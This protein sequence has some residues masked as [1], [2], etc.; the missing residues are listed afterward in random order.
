[1]P[2]G[3]FRSAASDADAAARIDVQETI[4]DLDIGV[5]VTHETESTVEIRVQLQRAGQA[6][7]R[8]RV[9]LMH[10]GRRQASRPT[11]ADGKVTFSRVALGD[12]VIHVPQ[13]QLELGLS[14]RGQ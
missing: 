8:T 5:Q 3:A 12:Y 11:S 6:L 10:E 14:L 13:E 2:V 4:G 7:P 9:A 1:M